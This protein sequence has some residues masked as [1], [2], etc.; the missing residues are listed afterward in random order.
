MMLKELLFVVFVQM[1]VVVFVQIVVVVFLRILLI[2]HQ[3]ILLI[4]F[5]VFVKMFDLVF[6]Q[7]FVVVFVQIIVM[8]NVQIIVWVVVEI[9]VWVFVLL[10]LQ[11][12]VQQQTL[13]LVVFLVFVLFVRCQPW[14]FTP[15]KM[16][17]RNPWSTNG[18]DTVTF[19]ILCNL[20]IERLRSWSMN[21]VTGSNITQTII[22]HFLDGKWH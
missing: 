6:V 16:F 9:V 8:V 17:S 14:R 18:A 11:L 3:N 4:V 13:F 2:Q 7:T 1:I 19:P 12:L 15:H 22:N 10:I 21:A 20:S 5:V